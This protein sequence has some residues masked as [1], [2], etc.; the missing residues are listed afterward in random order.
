[1]SIAHYI[2]EASLHLSRLSIKVALAIDVR[3]L[4][5]LELCAHFGQLRPSQ[6]IGDRR[7]LASRTRWPRMA[8]DV[9][10]SQ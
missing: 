10:S 5:E 9:N 4:D 3:V 8:V 7:E 1:M 2:R 6:I